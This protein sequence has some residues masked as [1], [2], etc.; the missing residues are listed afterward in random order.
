MTK[1]ELW[2]NAVYFDNEA[3]HIETYE[4]R[5]DAKEAL[6]TKAYHADL[7]HTDY[8]IRETTEDGEA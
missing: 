3:S 1:Y 4:T 2:R 7:L 5:A 6:R 8:E